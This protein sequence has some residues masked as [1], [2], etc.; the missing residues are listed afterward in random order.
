MEERN[1]GV[2]EHLPRRRP[3]V[4]SPRRGRI[5]EDPPSD[6]T[7]AG[8]EPADWPAGDDPATVRRRLENIT[9]AGVDAAADAVILGLKVIGRA[10]QGARGV[11]RRH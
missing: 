2:F 9:L 5:F 1:N 7:A 3:A 6:E 10:Y 4:R 11:G 8:A